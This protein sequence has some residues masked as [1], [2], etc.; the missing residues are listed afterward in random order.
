[1]TDEFLSEL[2]ADGGGVGALCSACVRVLPIRRAAILVQE[3]DVGLQPWCASDPL[4]ARMEAAQVTTGQ[5]PALDA[6]VAGVPVLV[7]DVAAG[8]ER[9][10]AFAAALSAAGAA[11]SLIAVPLQLGVVRFG[12]LD[13]YREAPGRPDPAV[14]SAGL[15]IADL[16]I[17]QLVAGSAQ[18]A[19]AAAQWW[20]QPLTSRTI[21]Q[22]AGIVIAQLGI[23]APDAYARLRVYAVAHGLSLAEV[24]ELVVGNH[25]RF[26]DG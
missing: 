3:R 11:G 19:H 10:P 2:S 23:R 5:G 8:Q 9:W 17:A 24:A 25:I 13:L 6:V 15:H 1:L 22:A 18:S 21:H 7:D 4:A 20:D 14:I 16:V 26:G 12:V